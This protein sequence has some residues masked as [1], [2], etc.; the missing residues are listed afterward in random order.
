MLENAI[1]MIF[2]SPIALLVLAILVGG[3]ILNHKGGKGG[4]GGSRPNE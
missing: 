4:G 3:I 1:S 2:E